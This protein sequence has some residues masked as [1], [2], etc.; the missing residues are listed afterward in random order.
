MIYYGYP[1]RCE[2]KTDTKKN[3]V[4]DRRIFCSAAFDGW[5]ISA[6]VWGT[7]HWCWL[8]VFSIG[9]EVWTMMKHKKKKKK[10]EE[11]LPHTCSTAVVDRFVLTSRRINNT[12]LIEKTMKA[13]PSTTEKQFNE[14]KMNNNIC[15]ARIPMLIYHI[16]CR[17]RH[18]CNNLYINCII[19]VCTQPSSIFICCLLLLQYIISIYIYTGKLLPRCAQE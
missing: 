6:Q 13:I 8:F 10:K 18:V 2:E 16:L 19:F 17:C 15:F 11:F 7:C 4:I 14:V 12:E 1:N 9:R 3:G 5:L